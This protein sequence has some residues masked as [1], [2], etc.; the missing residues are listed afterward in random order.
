MEGI[1]GTAYLIMIITLFGSF[2]FI[3]S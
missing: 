2:I 1:M 3:V